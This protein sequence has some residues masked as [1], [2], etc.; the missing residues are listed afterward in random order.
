MH[1]FSSTISL[2]LSQQFLDLLFLSVNHKLYFLVGREK[3]DKQ[4]QKKKKT[5]EINSYIFFSFISF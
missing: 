1:L 2:T 5:A 4:C 3:D